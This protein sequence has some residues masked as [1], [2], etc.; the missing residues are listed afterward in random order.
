[1][2][3]HLF[4]SPCTI[5]L[6]VNHHVTPEST[7]KVVSVS[8]CASDNVSPGRVENYGNL[9]RGVALARSKVP[10]TCRLIETE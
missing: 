7:L 6:T 10:T 1:M 5:A 8:Y 9:V 2:G 3:T 4:G